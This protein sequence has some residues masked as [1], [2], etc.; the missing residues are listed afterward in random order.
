M[1]KTI[2][3]FRTRRDEIAERIGELD[4]EY[5]GVLMPEAARTEWESLIDER[6]T[7]DDVIAELEVRAETVAAVSSAGDRTERGAHFHTNRG[8]RGEDIYDLSTVRMSAASPDEANLEMRDRAK[9]SI[10]A[11]QFPH[12]TSER[13]A[14]QE[15]IE[16]LL[17]T[18]D[19]DGSLARHILVTGSPTYKRAFPKHLAGTPLTSEEAR[20]LS[21]AASE[22]GYALPYTLDP[23]I[24]PT[25]NGVANPLRAISRVETTT[26]N[27]WKGVS[28]AGVRASRVRENDEAT[29]N[30]P[31]L[32]QP[33]VRAERVDVFI[34][35]SLEAGQDWPSLQASMATMIEDAKDEEE[36]V[37]F[38]TGDGTPPRANGLLT[39]ATNIVRTTTRST[40]AIADL[41]KLEEALPERFNPNARML[42]HRGVFNKARQFDTAGGAALWV[43]LGEGLPPELLSYPAHR[44][45]AMASRVADR[46]LLLVMGDFRYFLIVDRIGMAIRVIPDLFGPNGRPTGQSGI[47]AIWRNNSKVLDA[48]AFRVLEVESV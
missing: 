2:E 31:T 32:A 26:T 13:E 36:A 16:R 44:S 34:P 9:Q 22:G 21:L 6:A 15:H 42:G 20:A 29:D 4:R 39:G 35:F 48:S 25:S 27:E 23:T 43:R 40:F 18:I 7:N 46:A 3:E 5:Q 30:A 33:T 17:T 11:A 47:L 14:C 12:K 24:I 38:M 8:V 37:S 45:S 41:Y 19:G 10:E 28:S 1:P